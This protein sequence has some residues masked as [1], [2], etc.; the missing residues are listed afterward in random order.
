MYEMKREGFPVRRRSVVIG[1]EEGEMGVGGEDAGMG[2]GGEE[3]RVNVAEVGVGVDTGRGGRESLEKSVSMSGMGMG[4]GGRGMGDKAKSMG[5]GISSRSSRSS[6]RGMRMELE[7]HL[8]PY[9]EHCS[10]PELRSFLSFL[11]PRR[12]IPTVNTGETARPSTNQLHHLRGLVDESACK[13][14]FLA[15]FG[16]RRERRGGWVVAGEG[17]GEVERGS[18]GVG[19]GEEGGGGGEGLGWCMVESGWEEKGVA[20]KE[21][22]GAEGDDE[23]GEG[24]RGE[25]EGMLFS[26]RGTG[27]GCVEGEE[28]RMEEEG[29]GGG[30]C[31][32]EGGACGEDLDRAG[33][34]DVA[35]LHDD[36]AASDGLLPAAKRQR[37]EPCGAAVRVSDNK[38]RAVQRMVAVGLPGLTAAVAVR[39]LK[40]HGGD[41]GRAVDAFLMHVEGAGGGAADGGGG[42]AADVG[43]GGAGGGVGRDEGGAGER[44][45]GEGEGEGREGD[46]TGGEGEG[47]EGERVMGEGREDRRRLEEE[48]RRDEGEG[49]QDRSGVSCGV[50]GRRETEGERAETRKGDREGV[51]GSVASK[52]ARTEGVKCTAASAEA[53]AAAAVEVEAAAAA[54][55]TAAEAAA[56]APVK[57]AVPAA[58]ASSGKGAVP[59]VALG[60]AAFDPVAHAGWESGAAAPYMHLAVA[61][62]AVERESGRIK[63]SDILTNTFRSLLALSPNDLL[64]AVYLCTNR[65]APD[66]V[67]ADLNVGGGTVAGAVCEATGVKRQQLRLMYTRMGDLGDVAHACRSSQRLLRAPQ[68]LTIHRLFHALRSL[69]CEAGQGSG[70]RRKAL[71]VSLLRACRGVEIKYVVRTLVRNMRLGAMMRTVLPALAAAVVLHH[72][73]PRSAVPPAQ[74]KLLRPTI[75]EASSALSEAFNFLPNLELLVPLI[76]RREPPPHKGSLLLLNTCT[77]SPSHPTEPIPT[78]ASVATTTTTTTTITTTTEAAASSATPATAPPSPMLG[79]GLAFLLQAVAS[80]GL[81]SPGTPFKPMLAKVSTGPAHVLSKFQGHAFACEFKYDGQR[82]QIV[83]VSHETTPQGFHKLLP[84]QVLSRRE[85]GSKE[86]VESSKEEPGRTSKGQRKVISSIPY[87]ATKAGGSKRDEREETD[88]KEGDISSLAQMGRGERGDLT[89]EGHGR[90]VTGTGTE[91]GGMGAAEGWVGEVEGDRAMQGAGG[92]AEASTREEVVVAVGSGCSSRSMAA[93]VAALPGAASSEVPGGLMIVAQTEVGG[94]VRMDG[95]CKVTSESTQKSSGAVSSEVPGWLM[96]VAQTEVG[97]R[98][99]MTFES[100]Q[101]SFSA[102]ASEVPGGL[103]SHDHRTDRERGCEGLMVK[104]EEES[105]SGA[106]EASLGAATER[107][108]EGLMVKEEEES[109]SGAVEASL[110][111]ATERGCEGLMVKEEEESGSG[112]VEASLGAATERGCEGLMVKEEE[113]SGSGAVE[114]SLGA[115]IERGCEGLMVK[116]LDGPPSFYCP[117]KRSDS[118]LK[119][120]RDY[121]AGLGDSLDLVPI[122]AWHGNGRKAGWF[123]PFLMACYNADSERYESVCRV[124]SGFSDAFYSQATSRYRE[125]EE[126]ILPRKPPYVSTLEE[127]DVWFL[128]HEVWEIRFADLSLSPVHQAALGLVHPT[129]GISLRFPRFASVRLDRLSEDASSAAEVAELYLAQAKS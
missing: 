6:S 29:V 66:F 14:R 47:G 76:L 63:T 39:L 103:N 18:G 44:G 121:V 107:G 50:E 101:R 82:A 125:S 87:G 85:R 24:G 28:E 68:P 92:E 40:A 93:L 72:A 112:A 117:N 119:V 98:A 54:A 69:S 12:I 49:E 88:E 94:C 53:A 67:D 83:P 42:G 41:V 127:P 64:P 84:F 79:A 106:V 90:E 25:G 20:E 31:G 9:S 60:I 3:A 73:S 32:G 71:I 126:L 61:F 23:E 15:G 86:R 77:P 10:F 80:G 124:M 46:W 30:A 2:V 91:E 21:E 110:G 43:G 58:A 17:E 109:G 116:L 34:A 108:C 65:I 7:I 97:V 74:L 37:L 111:A 95:K 4:E 123:S 11:R 99:H 113:E 81:V 62:D 70:A 33:A 59:P 16:R 102:A 114:A 75:Q 36:V 100:T 45:A 38:G 118:W 8:V 128:P 35:Q 19:E 115:S 105:G 22:K 55:A 104:E 27:D 120:K 5:E 26:E 57:S 129:R 1:G 89:M 13:Q 56:A 96:I 122:G 51:E 48:G 52:L 78:P